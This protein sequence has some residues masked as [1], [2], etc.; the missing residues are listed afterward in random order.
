MSERSWWKVGGP[1]KCIVSPRSIE[2]L[3]N[4]R[5]FIHTERLPSFI[6]G[7]ASNL[8][9]ADDGVDAVGIKIGADLA[10]LTLS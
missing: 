2:E 7:E 5:H 4:L 1:A 3:R 9:F 8:L 6:L 10:K